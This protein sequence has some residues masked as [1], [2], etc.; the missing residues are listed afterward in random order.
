[1]IDGTMNINFILILFLSLSL[2]LPSVLRFS[3][4]KTLVLSC[5]IL[6]GTVDLLL[7]AKNSDH[8]AR[9]NVARLTTADVIYIGFF[10][11]LFHTT[12]QRVAF[13]FSGPI[14]VR[15]ST[16]NGFVLLITA[17]QIFTRV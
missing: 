16:V 17:G 9:Q 15:W 14:C 8:E 5:F 6:L 7:D 1:M 2:G 13:R 10:F 11:F 12:D 3:K 4:I